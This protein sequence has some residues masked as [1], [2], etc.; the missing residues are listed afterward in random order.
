MTRSTTHADWR[1]LLVATVT[2]TLLAACGREAPAPRTDPETATPV[3]AEPARTGERS[4]YAV[5]G[6]GTA[7]HDQYAAQGIQCQ[8]CHPCGAKATGHDTSWMDKASPSF[9]AVSANAGIA[10]CQSCHGAQLDGVG[11]TT[12]VSCAQCHGATWKTSCVM[13]HGGTDSQTG[14]PPKAIWAHAGD[15]NRGG[16]TAE[17]VRVGT[18]TSHVGA[19][20]ALAAAMGCE[21]CHVKPS[22]ALSPGHLDGQTATVTFSGIASQQVA[23][24]PS[25][26]RAAAT[27]S[28]TYCHGATLVGGTK[29]TPVWT[30]SDGSQRAC[31]ACHGAPPANSSHTRVDLDCAVCHPAGYSLAAR[32]VVQASHVDGKVDLAAMTCTTCHGTASRTSI[33]GADPNQAAAPPV[34]SHSHTALATR[35]VGVHVQHVNKATYRSAPITCSECHFN[36]VPTS[37]LHSD[38]TVQ[39]AFGAL[40]RTSSWGGVTPAPAWNGTTCAGTYCHG[41]FKNGTAATV[42]WAQA[43]GVTC[44]SCHALPPAG[45]HVQNSACGN[46]HVGYTSTSVNK[47]L[48]MNGALDVNAMTCTSCH[49]SAGKSATASSP[50]YAAPPVD[51]LGSSTGLRVGAHQSHL[52]GKTYSSGTA[53]RNCHPTVG[54]YTT[55]H[56]NGTSNVAFT[57][58]TSPSFNVGTFSPRNGSAPASCA[59]TWCHAVKNGSTSSGGTLPT[60]TWTASIISCT[61]CH[62]VPPSTGRHGMSE[63]RVACGYCH[64]GYASTTSANGT[65][66]NKA[67]HVNGKFDVGGTGTRINSW[68]PSTHSCQP[69]CH[70]TETW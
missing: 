26:N 35:G 23:T 25:W 59:S 44:G 60:P 13:C 31:D 8:A 39:F 65:T 3:A 50:L 21:V 68:N 6:T 7:A 34:D 48:H 56:S 20:H 61:A 49:G 41:N 67:L 54:S 62:T 53:C 46:C 10:S 24:Q 63:H 2:I 19:T 30:T 33:A 42:T 47:A 1:Q 29:K 40:A 9:H 70:G 69:T 14:A 5:A 27:C 28:N 16:G 55:T 12:G 4:R 43:G 11:G 15:P 32:T 51:T 37:M 45:G 22:D 38:G 64:P 58:G 52:V 17:P 66:V 36:A 18:H 57:N